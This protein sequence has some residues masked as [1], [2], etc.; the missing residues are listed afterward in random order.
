MVYFEAM[1]GQSEPLKTVFEFI[2]YRKFLEYHYQE[3]KKRNA[4]FSYRYFAMRAGISSPSFLKMV[5]DGKRNLTSGMIE[6]FYKALELGPKECKYFSNLIHFNQAKTAREKQEFYLALRT[7]GNQIQE[8]ILRVHQYDYFDR[9]YTPILRELICL[10]DFQENYELLAKYV[11]PAIT[12]GEA[13]TAV[14]LMFKLGLIKRNEAGHYSQ[15]KKAVLAD[16]TVISMAIRTYQENAL[17]HAKL[18]MH[19]LEKKARHISTMTLGV[20]LSSYAAMVEEIQAF[21][22]RIKALVHK[23]EDSSRVYQFTLA[24]FPVSKDTSRFM[25]VK[26]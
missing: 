12:A 14:E 21:K 19:G 1:S 10:G 22:D 9:W 11:E 20:S 6:K 2:D 16:D 7:M 17:D 13:R 5:I 24:L 18:A 15:T 4:K 23:D 25:K 8:E 3:K 26:P